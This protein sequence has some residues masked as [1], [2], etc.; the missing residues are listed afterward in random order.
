MSNDAGVARVSSIQPADREQ[1][2]LAG[3]QRAAH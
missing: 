2:S 1:S 3:R